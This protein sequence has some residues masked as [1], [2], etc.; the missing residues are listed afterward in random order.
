MSAWPPIMG[1]PG[2]T[3]AD[4]SAK[5]SYLL[6]SISSVF[7]SAFELCRLV[8]DKYFQLWSRQWSE[9][10]HPESLRAFKPTL[11]PTILQDISRPCQVSITRLHLGTSLLTH[12]HLF[13][14]QVPVCQHCECLNSPDHLLP[15]CPTHLAHRVPLQ[16][17]C[18]SLGIPF[19]FPALLSPNFPASI[20]ASYLLQSASLRLL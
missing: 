14:G 17:T 19:T 6:H 20:L 18:T 11:C 9:S 8:R 3:K 15:H 13:H 12:G 7:P 5:S 10:D 1:I 4:S 16:R 2:N